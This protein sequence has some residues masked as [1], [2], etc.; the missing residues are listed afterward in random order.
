MQWFVTSET[1]SLEVPRSL[2]TLGA[3]VGECGVILS[4]ITLHSIGEL[5]LVWLC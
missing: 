1:M 5:A 2:R 3:F 4:T